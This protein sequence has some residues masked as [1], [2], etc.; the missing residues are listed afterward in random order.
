MPRSGL[1]RRGHPRFLFKLRTFGM[2]FVTL[3]P[4]ASLRTGVVKTF[5]C[6]TQSFGGSTRDF[7]LT[8]LQCQGST[9][10]MVAGFVVLLCI[11]FARDIGS[12]LLNTYQEKE[13]LMKAAKRKLTFLVYGILNLTWAIGASAM[14][15]PLLA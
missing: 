4:S 6:A 11:G 5:R 9:P 10:W 8:G 1:P 13:A 2:I 15:V 12:I 14:S 7:R 3:I